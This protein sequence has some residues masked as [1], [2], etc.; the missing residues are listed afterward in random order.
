METLLAANANLNVK[1]RDY[2][3]QTDLQ[4]ADENDYFEVVVKFLKGNVI[5]I[6]IILALKMNN[7]GHD[8]LIKLLKITIH[9]SDLKNL[10]RVL[11]G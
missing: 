5:L 2:F 4:T 11:F 10:F 9:K 6:N 3:G 1:K 8:Q 7:V